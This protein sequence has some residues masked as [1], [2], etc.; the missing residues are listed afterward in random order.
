MNTLSKIRI[1]HWLSCDV[2]TDAI[3]DK[4]SEV[5]YLTTIKSNLLA[6]LQPFFGANERVGVIVNLYANANNKHLYFMT[7]DYQVLKKI[8]K[9]EQ[10]YIQPGS[11]QTAGSAAPHNPPGGPPPPPSPRTFRGTGFEEFDES[12]YLRVEAN[13]LVTFQD[14]NIQEAG[15]KFNQE[16]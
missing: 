6:Y 16:H 1:S 7:A 3:L 12:S 10:G 13:T 4:P 15:Q 14:E 9:L 11:T 5:D 8:P 2:Y